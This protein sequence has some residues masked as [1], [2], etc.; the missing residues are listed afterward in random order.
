MT[1]TNIVQALMVAGGFGFQFMVTLYLQRVLG[2]DPL[3]IGLA[4][5]PT[6]LVIGV[7]SLA[8]SA[9]LGARFGERAVLLP[10]LVLFACGFLL[11]ARVPAGHASY[12]VDVLP[13]TLVFG[14]AFG[15]AM[16]ALMTLGMSD[17]T[18]ADSGLIS[19]VFNTA[20]QIGAALGLAVLATLA[21]SRTDHLTAAGHSQRAALT[22]G[23]HLAF[24]V[25]A[26]LLAVAA[27]AAAVPLKAPARVPSGPAVPSGPGSGAADS[28]TCP[29]LS[30]TAEVSASQESRPAP[31]PMDRRAH[32]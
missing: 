22:D 17:A 31:E 27:L 8:L 26:G 18:P 25:A 7:M 16:P 1:G 4:I 12:A 29:G 23:Y 5:A 14:T 19:G 2:Y 10:S 30:G 3:R 20:Q 21:S 15:L 13:A 6:G 9:R 11:L 32:A 28:D 24:L